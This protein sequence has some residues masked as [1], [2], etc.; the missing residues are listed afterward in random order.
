MGLKTRLRIAWERLEGAFTRCFGP[1]WNPFFQL[2]ALGWY[3]YWIV[4]ATGIYLFIFFDTGVT[5]AYQSLEE[6][7]H[8]QW[9]AGGVMRSLHRY[10]SDGLVIVMTLHMIR[11]YLLDRLRGPRWVAWVTGVPMI[12]FVFIAGVTGYWLVWDI[13]AQ[14]VAIL[15]TEWF[16]SLS[17]FGEPIAR[18]FLSPTHLSD[19]FFTLMVF[20]HIVVPL[21]LLLVMWIH[22]LRMSDARINPPKGL[23][24]GTGVTLMIL[25]LAFPAVSQA[26]ADL[27]AVPATVKLDWYYLNLYPLFDYVPRPLMW[28]LTVGFSTFLLLLPWLPPRPRPAAAV[29][30]LGNCNGCGRCAADC[31]FNAI[32]MSAR[33]DDLPYEQEAVVDGDLCVA[34]G[35]CAGACPTAMPFRRRALLVPGIDLPG[36]TIRELRARTLTATSSLRGSVRVLV[37][38]CAHGTRLAAL[39][40]PGV[41]TVELSCIAALPPSFIDFVLSGDHAD[42]VFLTGCRDGDCHH[43]QGIEWTRQRLAG[44]R[45]PFLRAR[46]PRERVHTCWSGLAQTAVA[47]Q[48][49]AVFR[50]RLAALT[51]ADAGQPA[52][53]EEPSNA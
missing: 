9:W 27:A 22:I 30:D 20:A 28:V 46:V 31:P 52:A 18:N 11:E 13:L 40:Q 25:S 17:I 19:R 26:P 21:F 14:Y 33:S 3:F 35:I 16:D 53:R 42:G 44:E 4:A 41:A 24:I 45:D 6:I 37:Y 36:L 10:A 49:L 51:P 48:E 2:G 5:N 7:T 34:C 43:R 12:W 47:L 29:V 1:A 15:T 50:E 32:T 38:G 39:E 8:A 23:A